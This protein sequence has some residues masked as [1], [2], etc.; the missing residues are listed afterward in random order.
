MPLLL[1]IYRLLATGAA[2]LAP[3]LFAHRLRRGK[4][5]RARLRERRGI[6]G[7]ER[8][9]GPLVWVH[10]ASVGEMTSV[11][12]LIEHIHAQNV[13]VLLTSGT[14]TSA[15]LAARRLPEGAIHQFVPLDIP[16]YARRFLRHWQPDLALLVESDLWPN[17]II[18]TA[19]R[20]VP[21]ILVNARL[22]ESSFQRWRRLP[23]TIGGL[24]DRFDLVL[25]RTQSDARRFGELGA[26]RV[27]TTGNLK[28]DVPA[29][30]VHDPALRDAR[31]AVGRRPL[32]AAASTHP[33]EEAVLL[34]AHKRLRQ[35]FPGLLT[36]IAPRHPERGPGIAEIAVAAGLRPTLRSQAQ[37][38][39]LTTDIY[40]ADTMG[41][42]GLLYRLAPIVF[43][44]GSLVQ[45]GGQNPIEAAK[46]SAAI[47][48]GP[49]VGNFA[50]IYQAL[51]DAGGAELV[52]DSDELLQRLG[53]LLANSATRQ[54]LTDNA[55]E[56]VEQ[57]GGA[58]ERTL[59]ALDP[60][61]MQLRFSSR[62]GHA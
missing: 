25:A 37:L 5:D 35:H 32:L 4:E 54:R 13:S 46:L 38:P 59:Y 43:I 58:F 52:A 10:C 62:T 36:V 2:P 55:H 60:Y 33:G 9:P 40:V 27:I 1:R 8:P 21:L 31:M 53:A 30:P 24:L 29:P 20:N 34:E 19:R 12:P 56:T 50:E 22:S 57:L 23:G 26:P 41:E 7:V 15:E 48:H 49:H 17:L 18:E 14:V 3:L 45:H 51:D 6:A 47:V 61:L 42:L 28:L 44:G 39:A 11:I 16:R